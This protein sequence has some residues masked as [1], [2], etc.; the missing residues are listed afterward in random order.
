MMSKKRAQLAKP[1]KI[2][3]WGSRFKPLLERSFLLEYADEPEIGVL[4]S[5]FL[6][7]ARETPATV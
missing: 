4:L 7:F 5:V 2:H 3:P 6:L 1:L